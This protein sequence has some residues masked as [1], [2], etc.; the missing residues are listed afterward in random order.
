MEEAFHSRYLHGESL[1]IPEDLRLNA[2]RRKKRKKN[3]K[4]RGKQIEIY[5][6]AFKKT[7][8]ALTIIN[9]CRANIKSSQLNEDDENRANCEFVSVLVNGWPSIL[10]RTTKKIKKGE[11]LLICYGASYNSVMEINENIK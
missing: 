5:I 2:P 8:N 4:R 10:V 6:D 11:S 1:F 9:D 3:K 7:Q